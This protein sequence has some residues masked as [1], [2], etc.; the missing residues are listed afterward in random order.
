MNR[1]ACDAAAA[2]EQKACVLQRVEVPGRIVPTDP[3]EERGSRSGK[4]GS[5]TGVEHVASR[6]LAYHPIV[7]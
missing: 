1:R 7:A 2:L 3:G 6:R 5:H 4:E